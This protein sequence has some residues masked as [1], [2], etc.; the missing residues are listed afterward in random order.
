MESFQH[1][2]LTIELVGERM[3]VK[4]IQHVDHPAQVLFVRLPPAP[5]DDTLAG[6][7]TRSRSGGANPTL[8]QRVCEQ[9]NGNFV[10]D[11]ADH[12][13]ASSVKT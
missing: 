10:L 5:S 1:H 4:R 6:G 9:M 8:S 3:T 13:T 2:C 11:I 12:F 7:I